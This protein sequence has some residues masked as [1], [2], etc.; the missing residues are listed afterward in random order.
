[1][2]VKE[3]ENKILNESIYEIC[4]MQFA[5]RIYDNGIF[6]KRNNHNMVEYVTK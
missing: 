4:F 2:F 1:M 5:G 3:S 6:V